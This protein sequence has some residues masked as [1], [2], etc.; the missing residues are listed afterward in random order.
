MSFGTTDYAPP[1]D[2]SLFG[3]K[4]EKV[5]TNEAARILPWFAGTRWMGVTWVGDVFNVRTTD[6]KREVG[7][8]EKTVGHNYYTSFAALVSNGEV[9]KITEIKFDDLT[10]WTGN[11]NR[12]ENEDFYNITIE[13]RGIIRIYWGTETQTYDALLG[14]TTQEHSAYR[15]QCYIVG[16]DIF[17]GFEKTTVMNIQLRLSRVGK[18]DWIPE[19]KRMIGND[20]NPMAVLWE[21]WTDRRFGC[22]RP[23]SKLDLVRLTATANQ[24]YSEGIGI[25]PFITTIDDMNDLLIQL[26]EHFDGYPTSYSGLLGVELVREITQTVPLL[27]KNDFLSDPQIDAQSWPETFDETRVKF[28]DD[29]LDGQD[30]LAKHH[31]LA[32]FEINKRHNPKDVNRPWVTSFD[33][34]VLI[35]SAI[36]RVI[37][38]PQATGSVSIRESSSRSIQVGSVF[39]FVGRDGNIDRMRVT[40]RTE[41]APDR[42]NVDITFKSDN[43]WANSDHYNP[44]QGSIA[45]TPVFSPSIP[46][47][48]SLIDAPYAFSDPDL[49]SLLYLVA[50][51]DT[52]STKYEAWKSLTETGSYSAASAHREGKL[53]KHF[54][55]KARLTVAY[56]SDT[57]PIDET[58]GIA[59]EVLSPDQSI[60][61]SEWTLA[62]ALEHTLL[63]FLGEDATEIM[64]LYN[65]TRTSSTEFTANVV[66]GLYDTRRRSHDLNTEFWIQ[67]R[68]NVE[69]DPWTPFSESERWYKFQPSF[70]SSVVPLGDITAQAHTENARALRPIAPANVR[71]N[72]DGPYAV[73]N[74]GSDVVLTWNNTS[75]ARTI[76]GLAFSETPPTDLDSVVMELRSYDGVF[77]YDTL[78]VSPTGE[79]TTLTNAYLVT[80][81]A[82]FGTQFVLRVYGLRSGRRSLDYTELF[83]DEA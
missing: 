6:V 30:N 74:L 28:V 42:A 66:R 22:A 68:L 50:R 80:Q 67:T 16:V 47:A 19:S 12:Q 72:G 51:G 77:L 13:G 48:S 35:A 56:S 21:W 62:D 79:T 8:D 11:V 46:F 15:G 52:Y 24:L 55:L 64:S 10:V 82:T 41:P 70:V 53:F 4:P 69:D 39:N 37:G 76:F 29:A 34:A 57:L 60:V 78:T 59:F 31:E 71:G 61:E 65:V 81:S 17:L 75:R 63:A 58:V 7:K 25:S 44:A 36:G 3:V 20:A 14:T 38:I 83:V 40:E 18:P 54:S 49:S 33:V 32:S 26:M 2:P 1:E 45:D 43:G 73:W 9:D 27:G 23:E 5:S